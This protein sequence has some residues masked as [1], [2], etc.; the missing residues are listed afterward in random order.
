MVAVAGMLLE[1]PSTHA[2][3]LGHTEGPQSS[4]GHRRGARTPSSSPAVI[5]SLHH[6]GVVMS[7]DLLALIASLRQDRCHSSSGLMQ[8]V[9]AAAEVVVL[10][11]HDAFSLS[12]RS[13]KVQCPYIIVEPFVMP[14]GHPFVTSERHC[15]VPVHRHQAEVV[16]S[17][18][19]NVFLSAAPRLRDAIRP[20]CPSPRQV[21]VVV[22]SSRQDEIPPVRDALPLRGD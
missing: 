15:L 9:R 12:R 3:L 16:V 1:E 5:L 14:S 7:T 13:V 4:R 22:L 10:S 20:R 19:H 6:G 21:G 11:V 2:T 17:S 18:I 8:S